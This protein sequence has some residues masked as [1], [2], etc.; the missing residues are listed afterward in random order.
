MPSVRRSEL[1]TVERELL[2]SLL[3]LTMNNGHIQKNL[4]SSDAKIPAQTANE[5]L[6]EFANDELVQLKEKIVETLPS[7]R[8][9][10]AVRAIRLGADPERVSR[11]L[12]WR[13]FEIFATEAFEAEGYTTKKHFRFRWA[14]RGWEIDFLSFKD[15][16][17]VCAECKRW[18]HGWGT[19]A[20]TK[21]VRSQLDRTE[22]LTKILPSFR[23][24]LGLESWREAKIVPVIISL[25]VG[26]TKF[27]YGVPVV[28]ILQLQSFSN[29]LDG[30]LDSLAHFTMVF[31]P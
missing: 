9:R 26:P 24:K 28:P 10:I 11:T 23:E 5:L 18:L 6:M 13:E 20:V 16:I 22:A 27:C 1:H 29:E 15:P 25:V 30:Y 7:Q 31:Q 21:T 14:E 8:F 4:V 12:D 3:K 17:V 19:A 2:I